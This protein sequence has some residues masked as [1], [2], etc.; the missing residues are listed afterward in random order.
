MMD[1]GDLAVVDAGDEGV[2][3]ADDAFVGGAHPPLFLVQGDAKVL[4][5]DHPR[6][7]DLDGASSVGQ[8]LSHRGGLVEAQFVKNDNGADR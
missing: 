4:A 8:Q 2:G 3:G 5:N 7:D 6:R 1:E